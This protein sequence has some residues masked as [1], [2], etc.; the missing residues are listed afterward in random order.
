MLRI[1][2]YTLL[3]PTIPVVWAILLYFNWVGLTMARLSGGPIP[4]ILVLSGHVLLLFLTSYYP[5]FE[6]ES[7]QRAEF[8]FTGQGYF[9]AASVATLGWIL[10]WISC[11]PVIKYVLFLM[12]LPAIHFLFT[13]RMSAEAPEVLHY[14]DVSRPF[15]PDE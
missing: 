11:I 8:F 13:K 5:T 3:F 14:P 15:D 10:N 4:R 1:K 9:E 2:K 6:R 7:A 12:A